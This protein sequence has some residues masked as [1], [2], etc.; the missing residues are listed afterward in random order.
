M[1]FAISSEEFANE[2]VSVESADE[3]GIKLSIAIPS[4]E[5]ALERSKNSDG[6]AGEDITAIRSS[7]GH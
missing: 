7:D 6:E 3:A 4:E 5:S 1:S 2:V